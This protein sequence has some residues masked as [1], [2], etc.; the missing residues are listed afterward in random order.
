VYDCLDEACVG[1]SDSRPIALVGRPLVQREPTPEPSPFHHTERLHY[2]GTKQS[3]YQG[4]KS[5]IAAMVKTLSLLSLGYVGVAAFTGQ[6]LVSRKTSSSSSLYMGGGSGYA[7]TRVGKEARVERVKELL[8]SSQMIFSIPAGSMTVKQQAGLRGSMPE[9]TTVSVIKNSLMVRA[10]DGTE[11]ESATSFLKGPNMWFF[12]EEDI[13]ATVK[14]Y[15]VFLKEQQKQESHPIL[16]GVLEG[17]AY[18]AAG[19]SAI[20]DLPTKDELYAQI[21]GAIK[22]VPTKVAR[23]IKAPGSKLARAIKLATMPEPE[24]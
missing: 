21:A 3:L 24:E 13:S 15:R 4:Y 18:D 23:V 2:S 20:G 1:E 6:P 5:N 10:L 17:K 8:D 22:A 14:A 19:V 9:G 11:Y 12:I 16:G 7:T